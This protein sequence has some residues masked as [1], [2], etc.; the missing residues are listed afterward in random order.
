MN[1]NLHD[2]ESVYKS[3]EILNDELDTFFQSIKE[4]KE[5]RD[6]VGA[7]PE[8]LKQYEVEIENQIEKFNQIKTYYEPIKNLETSLKEIKESISILQ[9]ERIAVDKKI[10]RMEKELKVFFKNLKKQKL[11]M[12][13]MF[14]IFMMSII[15]FI[16]S[17]LT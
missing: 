4:I 6:T 17:S 5:I 11:S 10:F 12:V 14:I 2:I 13:I 9:K 1:K 8:R 7:L 3:L 15:F 16:L